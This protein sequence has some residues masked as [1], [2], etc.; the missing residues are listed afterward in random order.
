[1]KNTTAIYAG[2]FDPVTNGHLDIIRRAQ[3]IFG[4]VIVLLMKN[5]AKNA[6]FS[7]EERVQ[8]LR[9]A[10]AEIPQ[11]TIETADGLLADYARKHGGILV[12][13]LRGVSDIETEFAQA[14]Y[15][16]LFAPGLETVFLSC[17][18]KWRYVS[19]STV[20]EIARCGGEL[21]LLVP[22]CVQEA[23]LRKF[24]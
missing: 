11:V 5:G 15:N 8:L 19:S 6:L 16:R 13:G 10:V 12:R 24:K 3:Q 17:D 18:E 2:S 14:H 4:S 7:F 9:Q 21:K 22:A 23:L 1:M 20:R